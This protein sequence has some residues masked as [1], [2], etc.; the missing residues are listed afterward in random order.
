MKLFVFTDQQLRD[1]IRGS[2]SDEVVKDLLH[3]AVIKASG[4]RP[5]HYFY[6]VMTD[7]NTSYTDVLDAGLSHVELCSVMSLF[8]RVTGR[9]NL[10]M[11]KIC[12]TD[13]VDLI[14]H[15]HTFQFPESNL[16]EDIANL[17][18][19]HNRQD[20]PDLTDQ[21]IDT[22]KA[23]VDEIESYYV[24]NNEDTLPFKILIACDKDKLL[25]GIN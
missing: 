5:S 19:L 2:T 25:V 16:Y 24:Y 18:Y 3:Q 1:M 15:H 4:V 20:G 8:E 6:H 9:L 12:M 13:P 23:V 11:G 21:V 22:I 10:N 17:L 14:C 7:Y